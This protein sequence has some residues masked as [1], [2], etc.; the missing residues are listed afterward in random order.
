MKPLSQQQQLPIQSQSMNHQQNQEQLPHFGTQKTPQI[1]NQSPQNHIDYNQSLDQ[2]DTVQ[3]FEEQDYKHYQ[4]GNDLST[5]RSNLSHQPN[6]QSKNFSKIKPP[7]NHK[8]LSSSYQSQPHSSYTNQNLDTLIRDM[9]YLHSTVSQKDS[10][11]QINQSVQFIQSCLQQ[12]SQHMQLQ[13]YSRVQQFL[14]SEQV[15]IY[16][17]NMIIRDRENAQMKE[18]LEKHILEAEYL[19]GIDNQALKQQ[20]LERLQLSHQEFQHFNESE[21][22]DQQ[23]ATLEFDF[24]SFKQDLDYLM[25]KYIKVKLGSSEKKLSTSSNF[26]TKSVDMFST[27]RSNQQEKLRQTSRSNQNQQNLRKPESLSPIRHDPQQIY[28]EK[29]HLNEDFYEQMENTFDRDHLTNTVSPIKNQQQNSNKINSGQKRNPQFQQTQVT[30]QSIGDMKMN[31]QQINIHNHRIEKSEQ[32]QQSQQVL[33]QN[34]VQQVQQKEIK[35]FVDESGNQYTGEVLKNTLIKDGQGELRSSDNSIFRGTF[36][37][38]IRQGRGEHILPNGDKYSGEWLNDMKHG[39]GKMEFISS[40]IVYYGQWACGKKHGMGTMSG[41][42]G[43][44]SYFYNGEWKQDKQHGK[45]IRKYDDKSTY[46]GMFQNDQRC[47]HGKLVMRDGAVFEGEFKND[48]KNGAGIMQ[49]T[50]GSILRAIWINDVLQGRGELEKSNGKSI[51]G[52]W[53]DNQLIKVLQEN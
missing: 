18:Q 25:S 23:G 32:E 37:S 2:I 11:H 5:L 12:I 13:M 31:T 52:E 44:S 51:I 10:S 49:Y 26:N 8:A 14:S 9:K 21:R 33:Q 28:D 19:T 17:E 50:D 36:K 34:V 4:N 48:Q 53:K 3:S 24:Q 35:Q 42:K 6:Q 22:V 45:G 7:Q 43:Q 29:Q 41:S 40:G 16:Q 46:E 39:Y 30:E 20:S 1:L 15:Q 27:Q 38:N 47:G